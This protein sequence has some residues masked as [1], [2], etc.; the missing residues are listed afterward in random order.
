MEKRL[1]KQDPNFKTRERAEKKLA[2]QDPNFKAK[3]FVYQCLSKQS[4]RKKLF[5]K[6][7][8]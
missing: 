4:A 5:S 1:A 8:N 7:R 2:R 6:Q 3:E